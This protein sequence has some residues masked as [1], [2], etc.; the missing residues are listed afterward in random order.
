M[1]ALVQKGRY[2]R[3]QLHKYGLNQQ[4]WPVS[5]ATDATWIEE[6]PYLL[7]DRAGRR[8]MIGEVEVGKYKMKM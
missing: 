4:S 8:T 3:A 5:V 1:R 2:R 6:S 7:P